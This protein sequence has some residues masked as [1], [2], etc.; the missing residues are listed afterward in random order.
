MSQSSLQILVPSR[1][2]A[3]AANIKSFDLNYMQTE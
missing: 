2:V 1:I 3:S